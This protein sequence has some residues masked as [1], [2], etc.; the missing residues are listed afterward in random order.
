MK[1][2]IKE[3][4]NLKELFSFVIL[5]KD[6]IFYDPK[7]IS[8]FPYIVRHMSTKVFN[9]QMQSLRYHRKFFSVRTPSLLIFSDFMHCT[10]YSYLIK[11]SQ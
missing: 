11:L 2:S 6:Y 4:L 1:K 10:T 9:K 3:S 5:L 7:P 8:Q